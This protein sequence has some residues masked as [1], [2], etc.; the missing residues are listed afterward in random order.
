MATKR[1]SKPAP[2]ADVLKA[3]ADLVEPM[4][5]EHNEAAN[6]V[7]E[8]ALSELAKVNLFFARHGTLR[9]HGAFSI[10]D[11]Y[12]AFKTRFLFDLDNN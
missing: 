6:E 9:I 2:T 4:Q 11:L 1:T 10:N 7:V 12:E 8:E 5:A 3:V